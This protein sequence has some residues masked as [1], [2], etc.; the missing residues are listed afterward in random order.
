MTL[1]LNSENFIIFAIK[2]YDNPA[3]RGMSEFNEDLKRFKYIKRLLSRYKAGKG[4]KERLILNHMIVLNNL[5]GPD[6]CVRMMFFKMEEKYWSEIK[7]FLVFLNLIPPNM[8]ITT[9]V[10]ESDISLDM[11]IANI[12]RKI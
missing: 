12:L 10:N 11:N 8:Q 4:L 7:T 9:L 2:N 5:F 3:C 6:A 1:E